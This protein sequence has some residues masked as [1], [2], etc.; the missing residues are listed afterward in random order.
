MDLAALAPIIVVLCLGAMSPGPSLA[1]L[2]RN[3]LEG[4]RIRGVACG[5]GHGIGFGIYAFIAIN[6]IAELKATGGNV[7]TGLELLGASFLFVLAYMMIKPSDSIDL[8]QQQSQRKGF[9]EGFLIA[10]LN[11]KILVFLIAIF[12]QF[13]MPDFTWTER[14]FVAIIALSIDGGWY[15]MVAL[16]ITGTPLIEKLQQHERE[17]EV[18]MGLV[19]AGFAIWILSSLIV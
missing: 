19:L 17:V 15:V 16:L 2:L 3:T 5:I 12:S 18:T 7:A 4:G 1:V 13:I 11:P 6:G 9:T 10:F 8:S 14:L